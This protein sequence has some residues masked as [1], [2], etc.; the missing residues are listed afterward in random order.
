MGHLF[1][2]SLGGYSD[3]NTVCL[4]KWLRVYWVQ[5]RLYECIFH[6]PA[7]ALVT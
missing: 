2:P 4:V 5:P 3:R 6:N 1:A 7:N